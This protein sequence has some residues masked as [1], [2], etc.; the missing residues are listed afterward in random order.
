[1]T[2]VGSMLWKQLTPGYQRLMRRGAQGDAVI[3]S[4]RAERQK[5]RIGGI[6]GWYVTL[7]VRFEDG[8]TADYDRYVDASVLDLKGYGVDHE[9]A[10]GQVLPVRFDPKKR[11]R[12]EVDTAA[13]RTAAEAAA[14]QR[15]D[16]AAAA[17]TTAVEESERTLKPLR[18]DPPL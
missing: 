6:F 17:D 3:V 8:S 16:R 2:E 4:A 1:M 9:L 14:K 13:L 15:S 7:R 12:V 5:G 18:S 11:S 10:A